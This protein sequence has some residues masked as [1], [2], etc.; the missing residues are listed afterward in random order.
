MNLLNVCHCGGSRRLSEPLTYLRLIVDSISLLRKF[1]K[2]P[3]GKSLLDL[4]KFRYFSLI[5]GQTYRQ[6][7]ENP[8]S[9]GTPACFMQ[10]LVLV[11]VQLVFL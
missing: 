6:M 7:I 1:V 5:A 3:R 2:F 8:F 9:Y 10:S 4:Q 11:T